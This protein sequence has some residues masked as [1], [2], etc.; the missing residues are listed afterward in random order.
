MQRLF[1]RTLAL[2]GALGLVLLLASSAAR[3]QYTL[4]KLDS[5]LAGKAKHQDPLLINGWGLAY[6]PGQAFWVSDE[7][8]GWSTLY[9][10]T[11]VPQ[12][13]QVVIPPATSGVG[14]PTGM[15][16][17]AS[18]QFEVAGKSG[19]PWPS[20]FLFAT[21]D[22][23]IQGWTSLSNPKSAIIAV[24]NSGSGAAYTGL[25]ITSK[26]SGNFIFATDV[27]NNKVDI[28]DGTFT[29]VTSFTDTTLPA[30]YAPFGIQDI[31]GQLYVAFAPVSG[32]ANGV[33]D[34][35]T[36]AGVF[37]KRFAKGKPL[38]QPWGFALAPADFGTLSNTLLVSNNTN[39]GTINGFSLSTGKLVGTIT[40][41]SG[42]NITI[43]Q[44]W[45]IEFGGGSANNGK[46]NHLF[47]TAG[48]NN[49]VNGTF[50]VIAVAK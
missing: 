27:N 6:S 48:P 11:G 18:S 41:T 47:F 20:I 35:Y 37:V 26:P 3:A 22:G 38:N 44:L 25:A 43:D 39:S 31:G 13:L 42:K 17:N 12:S 30:G 23:T 8:S 14:S 33:V 19:E 34:I 5:N 10:A 15:V 50:G 40:G 9:N 32:A 21:L 4:T 7:G 36:E 29:F 1:G 49:N 46:T 45:G 2:T 24:N 16:Y 28:Y